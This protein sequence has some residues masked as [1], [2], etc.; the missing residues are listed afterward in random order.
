MKSQ[1]LQVGAWVT[2]TPSNPQLDA[3]TGELLAVDGQTIALLP[4]AG[5]GVQP[6]VLHR[7]LKT[8]T[9]SLAANADDL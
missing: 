2:W 5:H 8:G 9:M 7:S 3:V 6:R 1:D 4:I